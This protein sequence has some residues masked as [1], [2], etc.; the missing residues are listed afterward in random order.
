MPVDPYRDSRCYVGKRTRVP[1]GCSSLQS[2]HCLGCSASDFRLQRLHGES[3]R[4]HVL[5]AWIH[6][7]G[8]DGG[9]LRQLVP[10]SESRGRGETAVHRTRRSQTTTARHHQ[11]ATI[12]HT[13]QRKSK[14]KHQVNKARTM[15]L[16][17][18]C[19]I[20]APTML[21][22]PHHACTLF[23]DGLAGTREAPKKR[24]LGKNTWTVTSPSELIP[25][26]R[27]DVA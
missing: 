25:K 10:L 13:R 9:P 8:A 21:W 27:G 12:S 7:G 18:C 11:K 3:R 19:P 24:G 5:P 23:L 6:R 20:S 17:H 4:S 15:A 14:C 26:V 16:T 1:E 22:S 2:S